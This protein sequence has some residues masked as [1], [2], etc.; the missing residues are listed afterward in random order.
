V[1]WLIVGFSRFLSQDVARQNAAHA[2]GRV[3]RARQERAEVEQFLARLDSH[4][5]AG[6][7]PSSGASVSL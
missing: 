3:M 5:P 2:A 6:A 4:Q 1:N 7:G